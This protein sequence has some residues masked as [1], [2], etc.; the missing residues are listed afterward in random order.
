MKN[1]CLIGRQKFLFIFLTTSNDKYSFDRTMTK[2]MKDNQP[3]IFAVFF[4]LQ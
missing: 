4:Y 2:A 3:S 1:I